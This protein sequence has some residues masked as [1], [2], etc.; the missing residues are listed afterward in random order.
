MSPLGTGFPRFPKNTLS[1]NAPD[2][3]IPVTPLVP[4]VPLEYNELILIAP[5]LLEFIS[6]RI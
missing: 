3:G 1:D 5:E 2:A 4:S 6:V